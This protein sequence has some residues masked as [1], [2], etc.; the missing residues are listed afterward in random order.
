MANNEIKYTQSTQE[1]ECLGEIRI[2]NE[3]IASIAAMAASEIEG[4][5]SVGG[6]LAKDIMGILGMNKLSKGV[7]VD[8]A[9]DVLTIDVTL[10]LDYGYPIP[11]TCES[12][13]KKIKTT[14]E[15][16]TGLTVGDVNTHIAS[17]DMKS[18][19]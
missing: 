16:M 5:A 10:T 13:Q 12:V 17:V 1:G 19:E 4:V 2:A 7:K 15:T 6:N 18:E 3:V 11:K 9:E 14:V 8:I